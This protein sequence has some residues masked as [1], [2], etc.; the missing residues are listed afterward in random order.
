[1]LLPR[2]RQFARSDTCRCSHSRH[3]CSMKLRCT[4][5]CKVDDGNRLSADAPS[6]WTL[7]LKL[8]T[9]TLS[10]ADALWL[11]GVREGGHPVARTARSGLHGSGARGCFLIKTF[12]KN[13]TNQNP[14]TSL[15]TKYISLRGAEIGKRAR[16]AA[17]NSEIQGEHSG[18]EMGIR[19]RTFV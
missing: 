5:C 11:K 15:C 14:D 6:W 19:A 12:S 3:A 1:M 10:S 16:T 9:F 2:E 17:R 8:H 4:S 13:E 7:M 18:G